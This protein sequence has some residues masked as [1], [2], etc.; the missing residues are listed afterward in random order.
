MKHIFAAAAALTVLA[1]SHAPPRKDVVWPEAPEKPRIKFVLSVRQTEDLDAGG[2]A[3][4]KRRLVGGNPDP[5]IQQPMGAAPNTRSEVVNVVRGAP[6]P[7]A[8]REKKP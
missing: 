2:W 8:P 1:C 6:R 5:A 3:S 4:L 7:A